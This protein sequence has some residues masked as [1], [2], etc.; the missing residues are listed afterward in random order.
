MFELENM[1]T[2]PKADVGSLFYKRKLTVYNLTAMISK[3]QGHCAIWTE[4]ISSLAG[5]D[6]ASAFI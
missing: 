2:F 6:K 4:S 5:N 3:K 1:V